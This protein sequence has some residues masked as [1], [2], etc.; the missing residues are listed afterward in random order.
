MLC[1]RLTFPAPHVR[2]FLNGSYTRI[3]KPFPTPRLA[4][5]PAHRVLLSTSASSPTAATMATEVGSNKMYGGFNKRFSH[6][7][8]QCGCEM[9]FTVFL[10]PSA[11]EATKV[12]VSDPLCSSHVNSIAHFHH[13]IA[14]RMA[15][16]ESHVTTF[17][18][19]V[20]F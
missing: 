3:T 13:A 10:P 14:T 19:D 20:P 17:G 1:S 8:E 2:S 7:S 15:C 4:P 9:R 12:P 16:P 5:R 6:I 11:S 18:D